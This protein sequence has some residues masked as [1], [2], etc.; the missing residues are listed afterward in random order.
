[1]GTKRED[2]AYGQSAFMRADEW[3]GKSLSV[4][5]EGIEDV[6]FEKGLKPVLKLR[7]QEKGLVVNATNFDTLADVFGSNP[8]KWPGHT[9]VLKGEKVLFKGKRVDS[10]RVIVPEQSRPKPALAQTKPSDE[11]DDE[12][13]DDFAV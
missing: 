7:G 1:M 5:I 9:I 13:P 2:Y 10:I 6:E 12:I 3:A 8:S 11:M 4:Y